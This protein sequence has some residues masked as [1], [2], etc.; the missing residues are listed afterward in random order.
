MSVYLRVL[1]MVFSLIGL[2][3]YSP[4]SLAAEGDKLNN[5]EYLVGDSLYRQLQ[6]PLTVSWKRVEFRQVLDQLSET[7]HISL[8]A[9]RQLDP[10]RLITLEADQ[11]PL[12]LILFEVARQSGAELSVQANYV[13]VGIPR[14]ARLLRTMIARK[15]EEMSMPGLEPIAGSRE[16]KGRTGDLQWEKLTTPQELL[17]E[18]GANFTLE[19]TNPEE[20]PHDL[21]AAGCIPRANLEQQLCTLL[22]QYDFSY[23]WVEPGKKIKIVP[24]PRNFT[25]EQ[26]HRVPTTRRDALSAE[27]GERGVAAWEWVGENRLRVVGRVE[28]HE[29]VTSQTKAPRKSDTSPTE[30]EMALGKRRFTIKQEGVAVMS[31]IEQ[32]RKLGIE[33]EFDPAEFAE[34]LAERKDKTDLDLREATPEELC[35]QLFAQ[36]PVQ[37]EVLRDKIVL[38]PAE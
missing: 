29:W 15:Q 22:I 26:I 31:V 17:R 36:S 28:D 10:R 2:A 27:L 20:I 14:N 37:Y 3:G 5:Q 6:S 4:S 1:G 23:E 11:K 32:L 18:I 24:S 13:F 12:Y 35:A 19:M 38:R 30:N 21:L 8:V 7:T 16:R 34:N 9:D 25:I 33:I